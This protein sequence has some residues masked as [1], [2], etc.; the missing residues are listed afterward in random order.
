MITEE[1]L[2]P[3]LIT[4]P[5]PVEE[6]EPEEIQEDTFIMEIGSQEKKLITHPYDLIIRQIK[7]QVDNGELILTDDFQRRRIWNDIES[8]RL[9]ESLLIS[10]PI[11]MC[12]FAEVSNVYSVID[13]QQRLTA[14][15]RF[16]NNEFS[17]DSLH[18]RPDL[19]GRKFCNLG[20]ANT[21]TLLNRSIRCIVILKESD[22]DI[23]LNVFARLSSSSVQLNAQE[24]RSGLYGE[25]LNKLLMEL[26]MNPVFKVCNGRF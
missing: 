20:V 10:L 7:E 25:G 19:N 12:Y 15:Y 11:P 23:R 13:G 16:M 5:L 4:E 26:S 14:I 18:I 6:F 24:L 9:I 2:I 3:T 21:R 22:P 17:L 1:L 8:S